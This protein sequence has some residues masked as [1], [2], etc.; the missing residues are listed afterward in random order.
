M[1]APAS[2]LLFGYLLP[3]V[4]STG[5]MAYY[6]YSDVQQDLQHDECDEGL[7][8]PP[9]VVTV[10]DVLKGVL[11][12]VLPLFNWI[13]PLRFVWEAAKDLEYRLSQ[14]LQKPL[15][16]KRRKA[17]TEAPKR[18]SEDRNDS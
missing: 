13:I 17:L 7:C 10:G 14:P 18:R 15:V 2:I 3:L 4:L 5:I 1:I 6:L 11:L 12:C 16:A 8:M 9:Y